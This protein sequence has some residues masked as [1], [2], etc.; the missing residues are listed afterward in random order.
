LA[1]YY[2]ATN[3][4]ADAEQALNTAAEMKG[5]FA[6][7]RSRL[8]ALRYTQG[9]KDE[10]YKIIDE[11]ISKEPRNTQALMVKSRLLV[12]DGKIEEALARARDA[13]TA[14][15][16]SAEAHYLAGSLLAQ[17]NQPDDAIKEFNEVLRLNPRA[18]AAYL[19]IARLELQRGGAAAAIK[20]AQSGLAAAPQ[21]PVA[22]L[23][24][25]RAHMAGGEVAAAEA[26]MKK[27]VAEFPKAPA[28][29]GQS[30]TLALVKRDYRS[31]R[32][33]FARTLELDP[34]SN[35]AVA[36]LVA[37]DIA[38]KKPA[39][40][41]ARVEKRLQETPNDTAILMLA[42]RLYASERD[43]A[44]SEQLLRQLIEADATQFQAYGMLGQ[45]YLAQ[46]KLDQALSE[47]ENL[48]KAQPTAIGPPTMVGMILQ[49]QGKVA[50]AQ[51]KYEA[52]VAMNPRAA[53]A[54]NN[55]AWMYAEKNEKLDTALNLAQVAKAE[56]PEVAEVNDTLGFVYIKKNVPELAV[57][58]LCT[59]VEKDPRNTGYRVRLGQAYVMTGDKVKARAELE[60]VVK[61]ARPDS[62]DAAEAKKLLDTLGS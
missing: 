24:L 25:A 43:Y 9:K 5:G 45:L 16:N 14:D 37:A 58:P 39:D 10:A 4:P 20:A 28:V 8:A 41:K 62:P 49:S 6:P 2:L 18:A 47:F 7:A 55:L 50:E 54:A 32:L 21:N 3:R 59:A 30:G 1:D 12:A 34:K 33:A 51:Q 29:Q 53:V 48:A 38:E 22:R 11:V 61:D 44:K 26:E 31:A 23:L 27:L 56:L 13:V 60:Q 17:R 36:G 42:A 19:Q 46:K 35:E 15:A 52:V 40:A 57:P